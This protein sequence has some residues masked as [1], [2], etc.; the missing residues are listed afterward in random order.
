MCLC[1]FKPTFCSKRNKFTFISWKGEREASETE[2]LGWGKTCHKLPPG[3]KGVAFPGALGQ[4]LRVQIKASNV[5]GN[6]MEY[7][8]A[9]KKKEILPLAT[10][11]TN[12]ERTLC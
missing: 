11:W 6:R 12:P 1:V 5:E 8:S 3:V 2:A 9:L 4:M 7:H 10:A